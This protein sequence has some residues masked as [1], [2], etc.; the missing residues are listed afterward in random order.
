MSTDDT[1]THFSFSEALS[2]KNLIATSLVPNEK[3]EEYSVIPSASAIYTLKKNDG[4]M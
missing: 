3:G 4:E 1:T 2:P